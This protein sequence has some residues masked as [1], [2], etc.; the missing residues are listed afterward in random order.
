M[1]QYRDILRVNN[2]AYPP[3]SKATNVY[4][5]FMKKKFFF[6]LAAPHGVRDLSSPTWGSNLCP[7]QWKRGILTTREEIL[8]NF[9][10]SSKNNTENSHITFTSLGF[11]SF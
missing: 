8:S 9:Q 4:F 1:K 7:L 3:S 10:T 2:I 6:F 11:T 5:I